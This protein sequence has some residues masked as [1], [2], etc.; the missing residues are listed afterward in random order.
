MNATDRYREWDAAYVIGS[1]SPAERREYEQ[2]LS[3]CAE[4]AAQVSSL[5]GLAGP[6][7]A[8]S[9]EQAYAL[10]DDGAPATPTVLPALL[11]RAERER[12]RARWRTA[13]VAVAAAAVAAAV[14]LAVPW[15]N[16]G[17]GDLVPMRQTV[18]SPITAEARLEDGPWGTRIEAVCRY[19][20]KPGG[21]SK[22]YAYAMFVT[23]KDGKETQVARWTA[24]AGSEI[25]LTALTTLHPDEIARVD[26]R[27]DGKRKI[28]LLTTTP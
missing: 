11:Q 4:C 14:A 21:H 1:L 19:A 8:V 2:H 5:A 10:L 26:I 15:A 20:K 24:A 7:A 22:P 17:S 25:P 12:R 23:S 9:R 6:L 18:E 3:T 28:V 13:V 27:T 16:L